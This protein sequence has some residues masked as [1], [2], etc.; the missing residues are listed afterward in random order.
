LRGEVGAR[1]A[2]AECGKR[3]LGAVAGGAVEAWLAEF[4]LGGKRRA[5]M[6]LALNIVSMDHMEES[7]LGPSESIISALAIYA[8]WL[9]SAYSWS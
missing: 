9:T 1:G 2:E 8:V 7:I 6:A 4:F 3:R 5:V